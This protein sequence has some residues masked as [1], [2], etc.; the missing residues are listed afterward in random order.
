[1]TKVLSA[2]CVAVLFAGIAYF[3]YQSSIATASVSQGSEYDSVQV[4]STTGTTTAKTLFATIGSVVVSKT[5]TAGSIYF[6]ATTSQ[7][8]SSADL[9]FSFDGTADEGTYT[10]DVAVPF[11]L[12]IEERGYD[13]DAVVT[14]R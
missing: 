5:G 2:V 13:G 9:V 4:V 7:A 10:Y 6:Y 12:L 8:T 11:G 14:Y 1:M 3:G